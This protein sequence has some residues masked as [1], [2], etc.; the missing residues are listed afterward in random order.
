[1]CSAFIKAS[2]FL[3]LLLETFYITYW[4]WSCRK[5]GIEN[6]ET[7]VQAHYYE[8]RR[9][10]FQLGCGKILLTDHRK[11]ES[12]TRSP[13]PD[14]DHQNEHSSYH[15]GTRLKICKALFGISTKGP[16]EVLKK[17]HG[18]A[19]SDCLNNSRRE[20][21]QNVLQKIPHGANVKIFICKEGK[22]NLLSL[23]A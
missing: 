10:N 7:R 12:G 20:A 16:K 9:G 18:V 3:R 14:H 17:I 2:D 22:R 13:L 11:S 21:P 6:P 4:K 15:K 5:M 19:T 1:M 8:R 23:T